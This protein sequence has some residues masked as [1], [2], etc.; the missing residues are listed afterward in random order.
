MR[1]DGKPNDYSVIETNYNSGSQSTY[2]VSLGTNLNQT[3]LYL[4]AHGSTKVTDFNQGTVF[5]I[6]Q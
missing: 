2:Y 1:T 5:E 4:G 6:V 3:K